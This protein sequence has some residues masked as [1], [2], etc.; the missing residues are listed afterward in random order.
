[1]ICDIH[2]HAIELTSHAGS[3]RA[4]RLRQT[5][6]GRLIFKK[7]DLI[8]HDGKAMAETLDSCRMIDKAV[9]LA[10]DGPVGRNDV[11]TDRDIFK[12]RNEYVAGLAENHSKVLFGT[13]I[14]PYRENAIFE[15]ENAVKAGA[16]L[17]KWLP[18]VQNI[19][20]ADS[21]C[22]P[23]YEMM[24][25]YRL[26]LLCHTGNEHFMPH[27]NNRLNDPLRLI[28]ALNKG[29][30]VIGA[31]CGARM[32]LHEKCYFKYW[33]KMALEYENFYGDTS[34]F[35]LPTR[36]KYLEILLDDSRLQ[37]K[38]LYASDLPMK[39][40]LWSGLFRLGW[41]QVKELTAVK[42]PFDRHYLFLQKMGFSSEFFHRGA[43]LLRFPQN[44]SRQEVANE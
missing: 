4:A 34:A 12:V 27:Q 7:S 23:F 32:F 28:P 3:E 35:I 11:I 29:V 17:V 18:S 6:R 2:V 40:W 13:S 8:S 1:M 38:V 10:M 16:C 24:A 39:P 26:P 33:R 43:T 30:T 9:F 44:Q 42:N 37:D 20:P 41:N 15:L 25:H 5:L 31:H 19:D 22:I 36:I 14:N 21:R